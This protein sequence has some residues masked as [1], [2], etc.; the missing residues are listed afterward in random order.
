MDKLREEAWRIREFLAA[1]QE[2]RSEKGDVG[3][4]TMTDNDSA[5]RASA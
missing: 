5:K 2:R 3:K 1:H 4:S